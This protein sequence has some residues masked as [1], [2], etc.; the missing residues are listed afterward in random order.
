M[1][2]VHLQ[3]SRSSCLMERHQPTALPQQAKTPA[4]QVAVGMVV[5]CRPQEVCSVR[6]PLW[7]LQ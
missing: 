2:Q 5:W 3:E 4:A 6:S 7:I 1:M